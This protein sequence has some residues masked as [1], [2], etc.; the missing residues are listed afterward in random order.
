MDIR[1]R[2]LAQQA[3]G[4]IVWLIRQP[5]SRWQERRA[6]SLSSLD[7]QSARSFLSEIRPS[8][9]FCWASGWRDVRMDCSCTPPNETKA[10]AVTAATVIRE[11]TP[12]VAHVSVHCRSPVCAAFGTLHRASG[13]AIR[14]TTCPRSQPAANSFANNGR[15]ADLRRSLSS[16]T[17]GGKGHGM[18]IARSTHITIRHCARRQPTCTGGCIGQALAAHGVACILRPLSA[19]RARAN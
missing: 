11:N 9:G 4:G 17:Y 18:H 7:A 12:I 19:I 5:R 15:A 13:D 8:V 16:L 14:S 1:G 2:V 6:S 3:A 10:V